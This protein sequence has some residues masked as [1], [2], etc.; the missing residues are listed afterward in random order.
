[1]LRPT[2]TGVVASRRGRAGGTLADSPPTD[3]LAELSASPAQSRAVNRLVDWRLPFECAA[4]H[5]ATLNATA[6]QLDELERLSREM[7]ESSDW[8]DWPSS[9]STSSRTRLNCGT[10]RTATTAHWRRPCL[11][12]T[13]KKPWRSRVSTWISCTG[14]CLWG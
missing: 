11:P 14:R 3:V 9:I 4:T 12:A 13:S 7:A 2:E 6:E 1:M 10:N 5:Y 8:S